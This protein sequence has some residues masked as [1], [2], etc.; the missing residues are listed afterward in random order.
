M[1]IFHS[2]KEKT[3]KVDQFKKSDFKNCRHPYTKQGCCDFCGKD[4]IGE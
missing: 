1:K 4:L 2:K 3:S